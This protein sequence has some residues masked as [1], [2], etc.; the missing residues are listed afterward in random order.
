MTV[1]IYYS[2][3]T[4]GYGSETGGAISTFF[5][6]DNVLIFLYKC[7][8]DNNES[9]MGG[10]ISMQHQRGNVTVVQSTYTNNVA[11][12]TLK[13]GAGGAVAIWS[14]IYSYYHSVQN[15]YI[16]NTADLRGFKNLL[17]YLTKLKIA[18]G[19]GVILGNAFDYGSYY[20]YNKADSSAAFAAQ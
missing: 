1:N 18:G 4:N 12:S 17:L 2:N 19:V 20:A 16:N 9:V 11:T 10:G 13:L 6:Q 5:K 14:K 15:T 3:F 7:L 8:I